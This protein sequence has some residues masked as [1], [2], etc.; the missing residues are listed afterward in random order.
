[1]AFLWLLGGFLAAIV[2]IFGAFLM[3]C[4]GMAAE[5]KQQKTDKAPDIHVYRDPEVK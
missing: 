4:A 2:L 1:M 3:F 5:R